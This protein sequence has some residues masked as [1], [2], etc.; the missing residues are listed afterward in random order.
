MRRTG[1]GYL[2]NC[3]RTRPSTSKLSLVD[4]EWLVVC[5]K[6]TGFRASRDSVATWKGMW[7]SALEVLSPK[8]GCRWHVKVPQPQADPPT[9][10]ITAGHKPLSPGPPQPGP[11][12]SLSP[13]NPLQLLAGQRF[14]VPG[15]SME[16]RS[17]AR[18]EMGQC[19]LLLG[20]ANF[21][22]S[23]RPSHFDRENRA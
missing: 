6:R 11:I 8:V 19:L 7:V 2:G 18:D 15:G 21:L 22:R 23:K 20:N 3:W 17:P 16:T 10:V 1:L 14:E 12:S 4:I 5:T 9:N 13:Q